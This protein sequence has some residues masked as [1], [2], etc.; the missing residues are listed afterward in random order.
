[1]KPPPPLGADLVIPA[2]AA[3]FAAYFLVS[4]ADLAWEARANGMLIGTILLVLVAIQVARTGLAIVRGRGS[5]R[6]DPLW[7]PAGTLVQRA[8][9]VLITALFIASLQWLGLT[10]GLLIALFAALWAMGVRRALVLVVLPLTVAASAY[11]LFIL[12]LQAD[13]PHGPI[14]RL[15]S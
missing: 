1:M 13:F 12:L 15:L 5:L 14:E 3:A 8:S 11:L 6:A 4:I 2:L 10:L 9:L 7:L